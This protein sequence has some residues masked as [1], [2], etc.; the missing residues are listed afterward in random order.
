M[1]RITSLS[2]SRSLKNEIGLFTIPDVACKL[3]ESNI[4]P[5]LTL[6]LFKQ[7]IDKFVRDAIENADLNNLIEGEIDD[8]KIKQ[9]EQ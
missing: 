3:C 9:M 7:T 4:D 6:G 5:A 8:I 1:S 2:S